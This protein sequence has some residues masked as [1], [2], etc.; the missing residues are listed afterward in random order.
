MERIK[1]LFRFL[2]LNKKASILSLLVEVL[3]SPTLDR[4]GLTLPK[5]VSLPFFPFIYYL[6]RELSVSGHV[7]GLELLHVCP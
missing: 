6:P 5:M 2:L 1:G 4:F 7:L 3:L